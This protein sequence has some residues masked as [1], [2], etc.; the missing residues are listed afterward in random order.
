[1][2]NRNLYHHGILYSCFLFIIEEH[3]LIAK[4]KSHE[5]ITKEDKQKNRNS[6]DFIFNKV[7]TRSS[8][9]K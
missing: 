4:Q 1:M 3:M 2:F 9:K 6:K 7:K 8:D 5:K